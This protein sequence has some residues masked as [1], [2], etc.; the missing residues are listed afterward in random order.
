MSAAHQKTTHEVNRILTILLLVAAFVRAASAQVGPNL[1]SDRK[2]ALEDFWNQLAIYPP[3]GR[4]R[5]EV[6]RF[7]RG[8]FRPMTPLP[9]S[10]ASRKSLPFGRLEMFRLEAVTAGVC[11]D[12]RTTLIFLRNR[13]QT[14][15]TA[16]K[17]PAANTFLIQGCQIEDQQVAL[18]CVWKVAGR[19]FNFCIYFDLGDKHVRFVM[20]EYNAHPPSAED[21]RFFMMTH[22]LP[23]E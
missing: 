3:S 11:A 20:D 2:P 13:H 5:Q 15:W 18:Y 17:F 9:V 12:G 1:A 14:W 16:L 21:E 4:S 19:A 6:E 7:L 23:N 22:G 10:P 8:T